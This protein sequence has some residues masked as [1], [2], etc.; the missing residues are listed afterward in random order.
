MPLTESQ[1]RKL[2]AICEM[3]SSSFDNERAAA[4][5]LATQLVRDNGMRWTELLHAEPPPPVVIEPDRPRYWREVAET[6]LHE[7][8]GALS[9]W[10]ASFLQDIL[11]RGYALS[12]KQ[13]AKLRGI[14]T[15]TG[16]PQ[17]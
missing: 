17:W 4:A 2:V 16:V 14:A 7:H 9:A 15:K 1:L 3:L 6:L 12:P 10:E 5:L 8:P 13:E 11:R